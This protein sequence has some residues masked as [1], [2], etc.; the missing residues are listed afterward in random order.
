MVFTYVKIYREARRQERAIAKLTKFPDP[1][2][3]QL[4][5]NQRN[6][7]HKS[8]S[9]N[10]PSN[11]RFQQQD[12]KK[13]KREHKAAKTLGI[14]MAAFL[15]CWLPF[16]LW[17]VITNA[18]CTSCYNPDIIVSILFWIGYFNSALNPMIYACFN[19]DFRFA[20]KRVLRCHRYK[21]CRHPGPEHDALAMHARPSRQELYDNST[22]TPSPNRSR[23]YYD[24]VTVAVEKS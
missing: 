21:N 15:G 20:F 4:N 14:I 8:G 1:S 22:S 10:N 2:F 3:E 23:R 6:G 19:R 7:T 16:F 12:R 13:F 11:S 17:Y 24:T 9:G 18:I 5:N